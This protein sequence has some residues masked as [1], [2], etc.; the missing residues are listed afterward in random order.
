MVRSSSTIKS[1]VGLIDIGSCPLHLIHNSFKIGMDNTKWSI[2]EF[3]NNL[4][5]WFSR[6]PSRREDYLNVTKTLSNK[7]GK[8]IRRFIMTRWLDAGPIIERVIEQWLNLKEYFLQFIPI[9]NKTSINNQHYVQIKLILQTRIIFIRLNFLVFL[10]HNIYKHILTWFQQ[11]QPLIHLLHNECEQLIRRL[12]TCF[13]KEDLIKN[14]TLD[15]LIHIS[16]HSQKNQ[17]SDSSNMILF[18]H[19]MTLFFYLDI[20]LGEATRRCLYNLSEEENKIFF[21]DIRNL[22]TSIA[23]ELL[24]TLPLENNLLRHLQ[25]LHP[26]MRLSTTSHKSIMNIARSFPQLIQSNDI[27]RIGAEWYIYQNENI[28]NEWFEK[29]HEYQSIDYYWKHIFTLKTNT[30]IDKFLA[31]PKLIK[32]VL[33]LSHGNADVERGFSENAFLLTNERSL[34]SHASINGLRATRDGVKFFGNGKPHEVSITKNLLDSVRNAHSRYCMD[35]EK[36]QE[37]LLTK[38]RIF[39]EQQLTNDLYKNL[40]HIQKMIDEGTERLRKAILS[41]DFQDIGIA[42][43]L[44]QDENKK[45]A[46]INKQI[47]INNEQSNQLRKKQKK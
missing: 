22:Y 7:V 9:N 25:C 34:L 37:K 3:L 38:K 41:K 47:S 19:N 42:Q 36:Q 29:S 1:T 20:D 5:F 6:S 15:E 13:I 33:A 31:L 18:M 23:H 2:E 45:L 46:I 14:K 26:T 32:C 40:I 11:T 39:T 27:D 43:L 28:P 12:F 17:K 16:Y 8:F 44:I 35:L 10:Y 30:G 24:R 21:N 4:G